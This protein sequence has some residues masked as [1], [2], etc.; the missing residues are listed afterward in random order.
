MAGKLYD[1]I[2]NNRLTKRTKGRVAEEQEGSRN[3]RGCGDQ[4]MV[5][6]ELVEKYKEKEKDL[7]I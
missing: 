4:A 3:D 1:K 5:L 7:Y 2:L 6:K